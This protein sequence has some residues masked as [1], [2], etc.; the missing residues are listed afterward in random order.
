MLIYIVWFFEIYF[1]IR[2][3]TGCFEKWSFLKAELCCINKNEES[4]SQ[5]VFSPLIPVQSVMKSSTY[6]NQMNELLYTT[7]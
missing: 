7:L 2:N 3:E 5:C 1:Y 4:H 6:E